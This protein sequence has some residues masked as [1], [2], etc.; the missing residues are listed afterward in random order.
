VPA[1]QLHYPCPD[2][3]SIGEPDTDSIFLQC[4]IAKLAS[5]MK[6][7]VTPFTAQL[8]T[9]DTTSPVQEVIARLDEAVNK[10]GS[11]SFLAQFR[12]TTS[13]VEIEG[14]VRHITRG[15]DF[16]YVTVIS[17]IYLASCI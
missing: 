4:L 6:K 9:F 15:N 12:A 16:M 1:T 5:A 3:R 2:F 14:L 17:M 7:T 11:A 8:V 10:S 13:R